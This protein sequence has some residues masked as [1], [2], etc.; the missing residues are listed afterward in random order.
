MFAKAKHTSKCVTDMDVDF[1][2]GEIS[3]FA[4]FTKCKLFTKCR[5]LRK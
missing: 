3:H 1:L 2:R 5:D 4:P